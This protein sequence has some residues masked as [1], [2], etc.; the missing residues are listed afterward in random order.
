MRRQ[1]G[2]GGEKDKF[3]IFIR[4][5]NNEGV[6]VMNN[7]STKEWLFCS[8]NGVNHKDTDSKCIVIIV[9]IRKYNRTS[10]PKIEFRNLDNDP[11][12][13]FILNDDDFK[14]LFI[15]DPRII[16]LPNLRSKYAKYEEEKKKHMLIESAGSE[17]ES[18]V[19][20]ESPPQPSKNDIIYFKQYENRTGKTITNDN[21]ND[22]A[23]QLVDDFAASIGDDL[24]FD[25]NVEIGNKVILLQAYVAFITATKNGAEYARVTFEQHKKELKQQEL[26]KAQAK[27]AQAKAAA[28]DAAN[29]AALKAVPKTVIDN[30][31]KLKQA[32]LKIIG[33]CMLTAK[34]YLVDCSFKESNFELTFQYYHPSTV[35]KAKQMN[36]LYI[37]GK[38]KINDLF[39][40]FNYEPLKSQGRFKQSS[41]FINVAAKI[42]DIAKNVGFHTNRNSTIEEPTTTIVERYNRDHELFSNYL[43]KNKKE[44]SDLDD[45]LTVANWIKDEIWNGYTQVDKNKHSV[46][47][48]IKQGGLF[49]IGA[50][51]VDTS[52]QDPDWARD[53]VSLYEMLAPVFKCVFEAQERLLPKP[54][55]PPQPPK[56]PPQTKAATSFPKPSVAA[57]SFPS[58]Y[59]ESVPVVK[60]GHVFR[61]RDVVKVPGDGTCLFHSAAIGLR[62]M[63]QYNGNG[64]DLRQRTAQYLKDNLK[65]GADLTFEHSDDMTFLDY[66]MQNEH[67]PHG[68]EPTDFM[69]KHIAEIATGK[70]G[71]D[72]EVWALSKI[73]L[74]VNIIVYTASGNP[75]DPNTPL[76]TLMSNG[77]EWFPTIRIYNA[78][79]NSPFGTHYD[80]LP[81]SPAIDINAKVDLKPC[82][83]LDMGVPVVLKNGKTKLFISGLHGNHKNCVE[84]IVGTEIIH[85]NSLHSGLVRIT[86]TPLNNSSVIYNNGDKVECDDKQYTVFYTHTS[87]P[88]LG[89]IKQHF[90]IVYELEN[91]PLTDIANIDS[92]Y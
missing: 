35:I 36:E 68:V 90:I 67:V 30:Y 81:A 71:T 69:K 87:D 22:V 19:V 65:D 26:Q 80:A 52:V 75:D 10:S 84:F 73:F 34:T 50:K 47:K 21:I 9:K 64:D 23:A 12:N 77:F 42:R 89:E 29:A 1:H 62:T 61:V 56:A 18:K 13:G 24:T 25:R 59:A 39:S 6:E 78:A 27:A 33:M 32:V 8:S 88:A 70:W 55:P 41:F 49:G 82:P 53:T 92:Y 72:I 11:N 51:E 38:D 86:Q 48:K 31:A 91:V 3:N 60:N 5:A 43:Q 44:N 16:D 57:T 37:A 15:N 63:H 58:G 85:D 66:L 74:E 83:Q 46:I 28:A 54:A 4:A 20:E 14:K 79:G 45:A 76:S 7:P 40:I 17:Y 2:G